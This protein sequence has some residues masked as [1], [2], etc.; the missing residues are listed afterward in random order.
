MVKSGSLYNL[1]IEITYHEIAEVELSQLEQQF[2]L[3]YGVWII[4]EHK[5]ELCVPLV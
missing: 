3:A 2:V 1:N 5:G 4:Y